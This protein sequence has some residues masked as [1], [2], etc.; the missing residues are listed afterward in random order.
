MINNNC[1][2]LKIKFN[3]KLEC[4]K[5]K[6]IINIRECN[7]CKFR[8][9]KVSNN[10][11]MKNKTQLCSLRNKKTQNNSNLPLKSNKYQIK[12]RTYKQ[13]KKEKERY[14]IIYDDN[15]KCCYCGSKNGHIDT[16]EVFS[17]AYRSLS[18]KFGACNYYCRECHTRY[19]I[20]RLFNLQEKVKFQKE[21][22][23]LY[24][25]DWFINTFRQDYEYL[26][27]K[28]LQQKKH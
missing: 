12:K 2:H 17:G 3:G 16:N 21:L 28:Y 11:Q 5:Q 19:D 26:L 4:K 7:G 27:K 24:G 9:D 6:K 13:V 15:S 22:V 1:K 10:H 23:K 20:D 14:S 8:E 18:I 25:Y